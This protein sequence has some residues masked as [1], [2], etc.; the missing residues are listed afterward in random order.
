M[1]TNRHPEELDQAECL[2][3]LATVS[4]GRVGI[5]S[6]ALPAILPVNFILSGNDILFRTVPGTKLHAALT[7]AVVAFE[8]DQLGSTTTESWSVLVRGIAEEVTDPAQRAEL[9]PLVPDAW[10]F[11]GGADYLVRIPA[12]II[13]GRRI[14][15]SSNTAYPR[16]TKAK[17]N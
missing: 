7:G 12:I 13:S 1:V 17:A 9:D 15:P 16:E 8:A 6:R 3:L 5:S 2:A 10:A 4:V 11:E 14:R